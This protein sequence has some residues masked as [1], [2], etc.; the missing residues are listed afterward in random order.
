MTTRRFPLTSLGRRLHSK[1][2]PAWGGMQMWME[3]RIGAED[4]RKEVV[5]A[6][7][8]KN[9]EDMLRSARQARVPVQL[10]G[11]P[12]QGRGHAGASA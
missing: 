4:K 8:Q 9:L 3:N 12:T 11:H 2:R 10:L 6:S 7:F 1:N 5:Y